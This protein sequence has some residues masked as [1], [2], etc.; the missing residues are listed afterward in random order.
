[1]VKA[2]AGT[3][4]GR[5]GSR[6]K[7]RVMLGFLAATACVVLA[8][9]MAEEHLADQVRLRNNALHL[10]A[11][12]AREGGSHSYM[13]DEEA[14]GLRIT[15]HSARDV[16]DLPEGEQE[17]LLLNPGSWKE[18]MSILAKVAM[19]EEH[20]EGEHHGEEGEHHGEGGEHEGEHGAEHHG[21]VAHHAHH[22]ATPAQNR[23]Q[24]QWALIFVTAIVTCS[25]FFETLKEVT[26]ERT[27]PSMIKVVE[28]FFGELATLGFIGTISFVLTTDFEGHDSVLAS[29]SFTYTGDNHLL[30]HEFHELHFLIFFVMVF[31]VTAV[32]VTLQ[33]AV[34]QKSLWTG[35]EGEFEALLKDPQTQHKQVEDLMLSPAV[36][37]G[38]GG[39]VTH[40][41]FMPDEVRKAQ[42]LCFRQRFVDD[43]ECTVKIPYDFDF[44][45]YLT[46]RISHFL[47]EVVEIG[48]MD[49]VALWIVYLIIFC[50][51]A[52]MQH[53]FAAE[54][55]SM[56]PM[57]VVMGFF[58]VI[59]LLNLFVSLYLFRMLAIMRYMLTPE[60]ERP[61][62]EGYGAAHA[63]FRHPGGDKSEE[64]KKEEERLAKYHVPLNAPKYI[65]QMKLVK[66]AS[67]MTL[68]ERFFS[69]F[70]T[71]AHATKH[72]QLFGVFGTH[73]SHH[74]LR[75]I[76]L[77]LL[78]AVVSFA[79]IVSILFPYF[80]AISPVLPFLSILPACA[81]LFMT[82]R[83]VV[84][85]TWCCSIEMKKDSETIIEVIRQQKQAKLMN[86]LRILSML[87]YFLD[88][89]EFLK[90]LSEKGADTSD[91][92]AISDERWNKLMSETDPKVVEDLENLF[93]AFDDDHSGEL[94]ES[95]VAELVA[96]LGTKLS[97]EE[98]HNLFRIMDADGG[99]TVDFRE[100]ATVILHQKAANSGKI[101]YSA[102][103]E[104]MFNIFDKTGDGVV[105]EQEVLDQMQM[106]G[107]N[108]DS[109][110][111]MFFLQQVDRDGSGEIEKEE[112]VA[113]IKKIEAEIGL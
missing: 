33:R 99:G 41:F 66:K 24:R 38:V 77:V 86:I 12:R 74:V 103:A 29:M 90:K 1:M 19:H 3:A 10:A 110:S 83:M 80:W 5:D 39:T 82:P 23:V 97:D 75:C 96:Q 58:L 54:R 102:L 91:Q 113:Y 79:C 2:K 26:I 95:E 43:A 67:D 92:G 16:L 101:D 15:P 7:I 94:D 44:A 73:G 87:S 78:G 106:M 68:T 36:P 63:S 61:G 59:Q 21:L 62:D 98:N 88:Q 9:N 6:Q 32:L 40:E 34:S 11:L 4:Q 31:F 50:V 52:W 105:S 112:F 76:K 70:L 72:D 56:V 104:K 100:F 46:M 20:E 48:V 60:V 18:K 71:T 109:A 85:Y 111:V 27:P 25:V 65:S 108:W 89:V 93:N 37:P 53:A 51:N 22:A 57:Y 81:C 14:Q 35:Y 13:T 55:G 47:A 30:I 17:A 84:L 8:V 69:I 28:K 107:K 42:F 45:L 49:W 64:E